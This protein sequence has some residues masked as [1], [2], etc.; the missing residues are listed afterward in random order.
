MLAFLAAVGARLLPVRRVL[1]A[2]PPKVWLALA[3]ALAAFLGFLWHQHAAH[4][5][6]N[7]AY[8]QG[9][10]DEAEHVR[11]QALEL[12]AK[13]D[14]VNAEI[15]A[16]IRSK[17]DEENRRIAGAA[18]ALRVSGPGRA[19]C[20]RP[21]AAASGPQSAS[22]AAAAAGSEMPSADSAAVPWG[23]LVT[24]AEEH[25]QLRAEVLSWRSWYDQMVKAWPK[26]AER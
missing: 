13:A 11:K 23:W 20:A 1:G 9:K 18:D 15:A 19:V 5:A 26:G 21:P 10:A 2:V 22:A 7:A 16:K 17:N 14:K 24:R 3:I 6:I 8:Q 12:K 4:K 25:D